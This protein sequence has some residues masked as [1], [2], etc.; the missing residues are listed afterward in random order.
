MHIVENPRRKDSAAIVI[1]TIGQHLV[2]LGEVEAVEKPF[3]NYK[4]F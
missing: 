1:I 3:V 4:R 2:L